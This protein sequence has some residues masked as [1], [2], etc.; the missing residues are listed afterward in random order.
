MAFVGTSYLQFD[1][2]RR[3]CRTSVSLHVVCHVPLVFFFCVAQR[4]QGA[5]PAAA[6]DARGF[7][8]RELLA[9]REPPEPLEDAAVAPSPAVSHLGVIDTEEGNRS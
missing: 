3:S 6:V 9:F 5:P 7:R 2:L 8:Q 1:N 4:A